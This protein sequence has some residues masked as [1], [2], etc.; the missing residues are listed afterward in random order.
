MIRI[1][2]ELLRE[3]GLAGLP[4]HEQN[5]LLKQIHDTL[6]LRVG[7]RLADQM[8][9]DQL[10]EF[11]EFFEAE[12]DVGAFQWLEREF[13]DYKTIVG[14]EFDELKLEVKS[15]ATDILG[16]SA[17]TPLPEPSTMPRL[18]RREQD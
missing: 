18:T 14:S 2:Y 7:R 10:D 9:N 5:L 6:E 13:P 12:D 11:E 15:F 8:S 17:E 4:P 1:D 16:I 3:F